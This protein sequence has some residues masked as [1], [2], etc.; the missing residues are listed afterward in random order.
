VAAVRRRIMPVV[1]D[2]LEVRLSALPEDAVLLG[3]ASLV[4]SRQLGV[5]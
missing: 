3:A 4:L 2:H 1:G 5:A